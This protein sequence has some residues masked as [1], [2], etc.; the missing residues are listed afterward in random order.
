[1]KVSQSMKRG[2]SPKTRGNRNN[3]DYYPTASQL[4][5]V[6]VQNQQNQ[7]AVMLSILH[8]LAEK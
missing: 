2:T 6:L 7:Q 4:L 5:S 1:M 8:K 3:K